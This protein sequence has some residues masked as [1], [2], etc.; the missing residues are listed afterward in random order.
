MRP[1]ADQGIGSQV[2]AHLVD[3]EAPAPKVLQHDAVL[4]GDRVTPVSGLDLAKAAAVRHDT[5]HRRGG[6][7]DADTGVGGQPGVLASCV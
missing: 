2:R 5:W 3:I 6:A 1:D 7:R 4:L